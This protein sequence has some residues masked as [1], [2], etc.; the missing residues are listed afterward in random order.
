MKKLITLIILLTLG[1]ALMAQQ[2]SNAGK[3]S[4]TDSLMNALSAD[5]SKHEP[6]LSAFQATRLIFSPSTE[7]VKKKNFNFLILHRF[8]DIGT[9]EGGARTFYGLDAVN[10]VYIG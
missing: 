8:G 6:I 2:K 9:A 10:D 4:S 7:T 1:T 5:S 3:A